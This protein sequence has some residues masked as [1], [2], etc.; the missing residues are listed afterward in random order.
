MWTFVL[1]LFLPLALLFIKAPLRISLP[2][3]QQKPLIVASPSAILEMPRKT[4]AV[5]TTP[6]GTTEKIEEHLYRTFVGAD[7]AMGTPGEILSALNTYRHN[8]H[9]NNDLSADPKLCALAQNRA[10]E[11]EKTTTLDKHQGLSEYLSDP[12][13]WEEL[14][15]TSIGENSSYGYVL[16]GVHLVEWVFDADEEHKANQLNPDWTLACA[17][18]AGK[19]VDIIFGKR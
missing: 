2:P 10:A 11:Q 3:P 7:P 5:D 4:I 15:I 18:V 6:W 14:G 1:A 17:G 8:H 13:H 16:S 12:K 19:T 9:V